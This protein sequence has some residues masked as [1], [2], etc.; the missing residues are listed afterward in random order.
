MAPETSRLHWEGTITPA[1]DKCH[2]NSDKAIH[3]LNNVN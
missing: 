1:E 2:T 3:Q